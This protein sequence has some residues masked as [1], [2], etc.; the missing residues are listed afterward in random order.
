MIDL[1]T[2]TRT[3]L[4]AAIS[5][6]VR[7]HR[8]DAPAVQAVQERTYIGR[9]NA[10]KKW[11]GSYRVTR[12]RGSDEAVATVLKFADEVRCDP[13]VR[14]SYDELISNFDS[15]HEKCLS[16]VRR[17]NKRNFRDLSSFTSKS[18][19]CCYPSAV[20]IYD[21]LT[22]NSVWILSRLADI[23]PTM[24]HSSSHR[25]S[26]FAD[27]WLA[28]YNRVLPIINEADLQSYLYPVRVFDKILWLI[29][30]PNYNR[31]PTKISLAAGAAKL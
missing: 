27:V 13:Y 16:I 30:Q 15:L 14:L 31:D 19:W 3:Y 11:L 29:A 24:V 12:F 8:A 18:L 2:L 6:S 23:G 7:E 22:Q 10:L 4:Q 9:D 25:Y 20:P 28:M 21:T 17:N 1:Q 5:L 26:Q